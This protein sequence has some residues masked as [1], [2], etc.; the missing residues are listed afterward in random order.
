MQELH[1]WTLDPR[2]ATEIQFELRNRLVLSWQGKEP[3]TVGGVDVGLEE[4]KAHAAIVVLRYP[5]LAPL[6]GVTAEE[7]MTFPY[8][9]GLLTYREGPVVLA[10]WKQLKTKPDLVFFDGQGIAHPR[11][12]GLASHMGLWFERPSIGVA[13]S[14]LYGYHGDPGPNRGDGAEL[15]DEYETERVIG[16][17]LRTR[18]DATPVYISPGHLIDVQHAVEFVMKCCTGYR[19]PEP[20]RWARKV[21]RGERLPTEISQQTSLF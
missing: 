15:R 18:A 21:A 19:L 20:I 5:D 17:V 1:T 10:A 4:E 9:P 6:E 3:T 16:M 12:I 2:Q 13:K 8:I 7:N 11:G 14:H